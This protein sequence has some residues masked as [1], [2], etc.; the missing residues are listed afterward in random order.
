VLR[1]WCQWAAR[2]RQHERRHLH[3]LQQDVGMKF[4]S[5][6]R[7]HASVTRLGLPRSTPDHATQDRKGRRHPPSRRPASTVMSVSPPD[8]SR[9]PEPCS[10]IVA[11][12]PVRRR[13]RTSVSEVFGSRSGTDR[14]CFR[15][16]PVFVPSELDSDSRGCSNIGSN[17]ILG[18]TL[19]ASLRKTS[20]AS[21][22]RLYRPVGSPVCV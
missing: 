9:I 8:S 15:S 5:T 12:R 14:L 7:T 21:L 1:Q 2:R 20:S 19:A 22:R 4:T 18:G 6:T 10:P 16:Q 11:S 3:Q 13:L 17:G